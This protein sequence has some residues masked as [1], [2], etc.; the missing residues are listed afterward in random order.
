MP[1]TF[2]RGGDYNID[3]EM[4]KMQAVGTEYTMSIHPEYTGSKPYKKVGNTTCS[5][6]K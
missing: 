3:K 2:S 4:P 5:D 6:W 1:G